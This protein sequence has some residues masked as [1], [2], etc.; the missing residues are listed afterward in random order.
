MQR[1][2]VY[3]LVATFLV[4]LFSCKTKTD[5]N[6]TIH[7]P[8]DANIVV[9]INT[10]NILQKLEDGKVNIENLF[11]QSGQNSLSERFAAARN[12]VDINQPVYYF[13]KS[14][15]TIA[16]GNISFSG[17]IATL[18]NVTALTD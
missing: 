5:N 17:L 11:K 8:N 6:Q 9:T 14:K 7:I 3:I 12:A 18:K 10:K 15:N 13:T 2:S 4:I 1:T 16:S